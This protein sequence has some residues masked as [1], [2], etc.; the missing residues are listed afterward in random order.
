M[1]ASLKNKSR[2]L[3]VELVLV[4]LSVFAVIGVLFVKLYSHIIGALESLMGKVAAVCGCQASASFSDHPLMWLAIFGA[5][6][7]GAVF[8]VTIIIQVIKLRSQTMKFIKIYVASV[9]PE[10]SRKLLTV[11]NEINM[12]GKIVE[13]SRYSPVIFCYG[14]IRPRICV[15]SMLV[16]NLSSD[17][18]K[19]ALLHEQHHLVMREP[20]KFFVA[21]ALSKSLAFIP[22]LRALS[23]QYLTF[24]ELAAYERATDNFQ[25]RVPLARAL[26]KIICWQENAALYP[27]V[28][29]SFLGSITEE[30]VNKLVDN[31]Y[32]PKGNGALVKM[33]LAATTLAIT[34][35]LIN[36]I[37]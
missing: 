17:E 25:N 36:T 32:A 7:L 12:A 37:M 35:V 33:V 34:F 21:K 20:L 5:G 29:I 4:G 30:R 2:I 15:S 31:S 24:S 1:S 10:L 26:S 6:I 19:A 23:K 8:I 18:L 14:F 13:I 28:A 22:G 11:A 27:N 16:D 9:K 3:F